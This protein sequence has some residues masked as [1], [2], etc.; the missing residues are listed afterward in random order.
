L[1]RPELEVD[2]AV[3]ILTHV[4]GAITHIT[5]SWALGRQEFRT[6]FE[7]A[8]SHGLIEHDSADRPIETWLAPA[9]DGCE[10]GAVGLPNSPVTEDPYRLELR[11][12]MREIV[13]ATPARVSARDGIAALRLALAADESART[14]Q[15][16]QPAV[17]S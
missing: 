3:A 2:H 15:V 16:V 13:E 8:G 5:G 4:S 17:A 11:E 10:H 6:S 14:G 1:A 7:L 12:F 9:E